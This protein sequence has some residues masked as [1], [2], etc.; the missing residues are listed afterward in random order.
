[1][2]TASERRMSNDWLPYA[3]AVVAGIALALILSLAGHSLIR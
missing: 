3:V 2:K 1:M